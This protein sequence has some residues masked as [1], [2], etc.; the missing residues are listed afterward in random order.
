MEMEEAYK[1]RL[2]PE[3]GSPFSPRR[4]RVEKQGFGWSVLMNTN[5]DTLG[6]KSGLHN[7]A[8]GFGA[9][10]SRVGKGL[11]L[12]AKTLRCL[13]GLG[14]HSRDLRCLLTGFLSRERMLNQ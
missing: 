2:L 13:I 7:I 6:D 12:K 8:L 14:K 1:A 9:G 5:N 4:K 3:C 11:W 10:I